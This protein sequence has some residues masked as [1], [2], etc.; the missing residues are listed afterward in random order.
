MYC[1]V[2]CYIVLYCFVLYCI[3]LY[4]IVLCCIVLYYIVLVCTVMYCIVL[5]CIVLHCIVL[6]CIVL[7]RIVSY[8]IVLY[9][10]VL[11]CIVSYRIVSFCIVLYCIVLYC[12]LFYC[13]TS[14]L[15]WAKTELINFG[16]KVD[17]RKTYYISSFMRAVF[18]TRRFKYLRRLTMTGS[19]ATR[20]TKGP[21]HLQKLWTL[22]LQQVDLDI[23]YLVWKRV[24][25]TVP[26]SV[27][28]VEDADNTVV[29]Q[30][31]R[32][33]GAATLKELKISAFN[34]HLASKYTN[35][36][37]LIVVLCADIF[38]SVGQYFNPIRHGLFRGAWARRGGGCGK[39]PRPI[40][41]K[42]F[43]NHKLI[44]LVYFK[45]QMTLS[46]RH[47]DVVTVE[48]LAD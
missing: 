5:Y 39:C 48:I 42:L 28:T 25:H 44:K 11:C 20:S 23:T 10:I 9:C 47:N 40:T 37:I 36:Y 18:F 13:T 45:W 31:K 26:R 1:V 41:L 22:S 19:L 38:G 30:L 24:A 34:R 21:V 2:L 43:M 29:S 6:Y 15:N 8:C 35:K 16:V 17:E 27:S 14:A 12:I 46:L 32:E 33:Y 7:Y 3:V 4:C